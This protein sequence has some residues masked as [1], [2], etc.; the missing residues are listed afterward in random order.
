MTLKK[1]CRNPGARRKKKVGPE[2]LVQIALV[3][4]IKLQYP[5]VGKHLIY[6]A[7][8]GV[9]SIAGH[10]LAKKMGMHKFASDLFIAYPCNGFHGAWIEIKKDGWKL[11][12]SNKDHHDGQMIF[13]E[14]MMKA[15]Y[16]GALC[17]GI[18]ECIAAIN[19]YLKGS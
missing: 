14:R 18:D 9:R 7:N 10:E 8:E 3:R 16:F 15:G 12:P 2:A 4:W 17:V 19:L 11:V 5:E 6:I 1:P 13:L